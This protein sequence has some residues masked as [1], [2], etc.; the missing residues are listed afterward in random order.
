[1]STSVPKRLR[2]TIEQLKQLI[3]DRGLQSGDP[4]PTETELLE[5]VGGSRSSLREAIRVLSAQDIIQ[6]IHGR[7]TFVGEMSLSPL[8]EGLTF[9]A[10]TRIGSETDTLRQVV[11]VRSAL[12]LALAPSVVARLTGEETPELSRLCDTMALSAVKGHSFAAADRAFH[13][14]LAESLQNQLYGELVAAFWDIHTVVAPKLGV[15][16]PRDIDQTVAAHRA[17]LTAAV[18]GRVGDYQEAVKAH[19]EPLLRVLGA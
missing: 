4:M 15:P 16:S 18:E 10:Q 17:M 14:Q 19:Y 2:S 9:K 7:G 8:V 3:L 5:L 11:E 13:L 6:V 12:D 1:M